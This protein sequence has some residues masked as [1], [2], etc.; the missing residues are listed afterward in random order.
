MTDLRNTR[1]RGFAI[2]DRELFPDI[3]CI[4]AP[5]FRSTGEPA[6]AISIVSHSSRMNSSR[7]EKLGALLQEAVLN[8]SRRLGFQGHKLFHS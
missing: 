5:V 6:A 3:S 4:A 7:I 2:D 1:K 8:L